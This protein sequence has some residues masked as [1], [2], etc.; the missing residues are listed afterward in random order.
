MKTPERLRIAVQKSGRLNQGSMDFLVSC[1]LTFAPNGHSLILPCQNLDLDVLYLRD[2]D[3]PEYVSR[4]VADFGIVG[5]NVLAEKEFEPK[6][7]KKFDFGKCRLMIAAPADSVI[8]NPKDLEGERIA[9]SYP[10]LLTDYLKKEKLEAAIIPISGSVEITPD[11]NLADAIC[12]IVQTGTTLKAHNLVPL[13]TILE[14]QAVL[15][16][17]PINKQA[18]ANFL[19]K[20]GI[21]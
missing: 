6:I 2:D 4:G 9:T 10:K 14:S 11:L 16:E 17:S 5:Q 21:N 13:F 8:K 3:I 1:G 19:L 15:I 20:C 18:K 7:L 12:D